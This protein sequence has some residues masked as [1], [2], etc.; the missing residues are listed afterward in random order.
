M[1]IIRPIKEK[2]RTD[3]ALRKSLVVNFPPREIR[4]ED[5]SMLG[6]SCSAPHPLH[7]VHL[8]AGQHV[9]I[10]TS[11]DVMRLS[12]AQ[13]RDILR[14]PAAELAESDPL[15]VA[16]LREWFDAVEAAAPYTITELAY[17]VDA[18]TICRVLDIGIGGLAARQ[19][20]RTKWPASDLFLL[21]LQFPQLD[22]E[23]TCREIYLR[24]KLTKDLEDA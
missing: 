20:G 5:G 12:Y 8:R 10:Q 16:N 14:L 3:K 11:A 9:Q 1:A 17:D 19:R 23:A 4:T 6:I 15:L 7:A 2:M 22:V 13:V 24:E 21:K 18:E